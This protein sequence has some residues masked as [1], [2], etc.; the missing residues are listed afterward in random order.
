[1][2]YRI[3]KAMAG[4]GSLSEIRDL[5]INDGIKTAQRQPSSNMKQSQEQ[6]APGGRRPTN[7]SPKPEAD[8]ESS[9]DGFFED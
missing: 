7:K 1:M 6:S 3:E 5:N 9:S 8:E 2:W 4:E